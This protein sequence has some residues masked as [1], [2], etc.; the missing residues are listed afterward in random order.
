MQKAIK[1][2]SAPF[3]FGFQLISPLPIAYMHYIYN[4]QKKLYIYFTEAFLNVQIKC[5]AGI[6]SKKINPVNPISKFLKQPHS[7]ALLIYALY[8]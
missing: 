4:I 1:S 3:I 5:N 2:G 8:I 6:F 7:L